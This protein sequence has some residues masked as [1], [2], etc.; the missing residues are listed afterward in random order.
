[1]S[2]SVVEERLAASPN[3]WLATVRPD[4]RPHVAPI[5]G[6]W[7]DGALYFDG[8][9]KTRWARN[10]A[11]SPAVSVNLENGNDA[12]ILEGIVETVRTDTA[13]GTRILEVWDAKYGRLPPDPPV[14]GM[15]RFRPRAARA[16][17]FSLTDGTRWRFPVE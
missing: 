10:I 11:I 16:W 1:M 12:V 6:V 5:W 14:G 2:W 9:P 7:V 8:S 3:Y 4:G 15:F 13:L 17:S